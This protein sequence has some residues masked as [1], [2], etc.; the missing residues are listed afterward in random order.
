MTHPATP[1]GPVPPPGCPA[2]AGAAKLYG[3]QFA[4]DPAATYERLR[5]NGPFAPVELAPGVEAT[6]VTG[7]E[8]ALRVLRGTDAFGKDARRWKALN[9]G[10]IPADSPILPM[11]I[12]RP[13]A[14]FAE[15][16]EHRRLRGAIDDSLRNIDPGALRAAIERSADAII[17]RFADKGEADLLGDYAKELPLRVVTQLFGSTPDIGDRLYTGIRNMYDGIEPEAANAMVGQAVMDLI[18]LRR[19]EPGND[20]VTWLTQHE[21]KLTE[22]ELIDQLVVMIGASTEPQQNLITNAL[23]L[24]LADDRFGG[25]LNGGSLPVEDALDEVLWTDP[26]LANF[27]PH[28]AFQDVEIDG[29]V[30]AAGTPIIISFA[31][32]T[33]DPTLINDKRAGNRAH[34]SWSAGPHGCPAQ[35]EARIIASVAIERLLDRLPDVELA[36][37]V[38]ALTWREGPFHRSLTALPVRFPPVAPVRPVLPPETSPEHSGDSRWTASSSPATAPRTSSTPQEPTSPARPSGSPSGRP[39]RPWSFLARWWRGR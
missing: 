36:V 21:S 2:H 22:A 37:P 5:A 13:N 3:P 33:T 23:R 30:L 9:E 4:Q 17:D 25:S 24:L 35:R 18:A 34:L 10:R 19:A 20:I 14:F 27:A 8:A 32:A 31:A 15:G 38:G 6:L 7:Y 39:R 12:H 26:P 1:D 11:M 28:Y 29:H 16:D